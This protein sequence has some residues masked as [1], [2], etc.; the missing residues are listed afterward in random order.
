MEKITNKN[1]EQKIASGIC[2]ID[3]YADWCGPC[4]MLGSLLHN[5]E[6]EIT[7][8]NWYQVNVDEEGELAQKFAVMS[9]PTVYIT[10]NGKVLDH[11]TGFLPKEK[12]IEFIEKNSI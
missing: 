11:F 10:K 8:V 12:V 4:K 2:I 3:F 5:L 6:K 7:N 1:F 9:I